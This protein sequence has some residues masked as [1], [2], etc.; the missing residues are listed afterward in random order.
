MW[1][2]PHPSDRPSAVRALVLARG[3]VG[4]IA[5]RGQTLPPQKLLG[6]T[7]AGLH[8]RYGSCDFPRCQLDCLA[9]SLVG[10]A[11]ADVAA[12]GVIDLLIRRMRSFFQERY[13]LHDLAG[14]TVPALRNVQLH[15][16]LL[17]RMEP[18]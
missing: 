9:N 18:V 15:P 1:P 4:C 3:P 5:P 12:H 10:A 6:G 16:G 2:G 8:S 13:G 7:G 14:L 17:N 11:A